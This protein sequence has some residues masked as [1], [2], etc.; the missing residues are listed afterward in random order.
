MMKMGHKSLAFP[1]YSFLTVLTATAVSNG[2]ENIGESGHSLV[3]PEDSHRFTEYVFNVFYIT[4][5]HIV[6]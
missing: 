5:S 2:A 3:L 4:E 6:C 1:V